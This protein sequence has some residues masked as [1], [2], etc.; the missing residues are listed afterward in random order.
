MKMAYRPRSCCAVAGALICAFVVCLAAG[1][2]AAFAAVAS[3]A[4]IA[5]P[6]SA[7]FS[8]TGTGAQAHPLT[9]DDV[10]AFFDGV[11]PY[12]IHRA[13]IAGAVV[14]VVSGGKLLFAKGYG[15]S[16]VDD[17]A[18]VVADRTL[19]RP[20]SI[21]KLFT[22]TAVMQ[23]VRTGRIDLD[24]DV[25]TY[26]DFRIPARFGRP[27]T[28]REL[29]THTPGFE[30][31]FSQLAVDS[32]GQLFP[33]RE[34]LLQHMPERIFP[35]G[36]I[37][38]Y[39]NYGATLA[40]YIVQRLSGEPFDHYIQ[41]HIF[42]PLGMNHSTFEQPPSPA[43]MADVS[44][45][46]ATASSE[47]QGF[48]YGEVV[49]AGAMSTTATDI[50]R[51]MIAELGDG[52]DG[53][54]SILDPQTLALMHSLQSRMAPGMNGWDLGFCQE[55]RNGLSIVWHGGDTLWFHSDL[56]LLLDKSV[57]LFIAFNSTGAGGETDNVR[58]RF[59]IFREFL[60]RYFP[61]TPPEVHT[62]PRAQAEADAARVAG[63]YMSSRRVVSAL[64]VLNVLPRR[65]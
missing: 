57:G 3:E 50:A 1:E 37:T 59:A 10:A 65:P 55:N 19:F 45:G 15:Y 12:A 17:R 26:L 31:T 56:H 11:I 30:D 49:P 18:P 42:Q 2:P 33:L 25:N 54:E 20:G 60:D 53:G 61:Y 28:M 14:A 63:W 40:G 47:A 4:Q 21:S 27:I 36:E 38:A 7:S 16:N 48:E 44:Q 5:A 64:S 9:A 13:D 52:S 41:Q 22:W 23:L 6:G 8:G 34:Y 35:P 51:F 46:Y 58:L 29:M 62:V 43:L 32:A 24:R 39:S